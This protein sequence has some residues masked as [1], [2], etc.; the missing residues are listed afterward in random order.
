MLLKEW[1]NEILQGNLELQRKSC[2]LYIFGNASGISGGKELVVIKPNG[3]AY[4][5]L[6]AERLLVTN[7][8]GRVVEGDLRPSSHLAT[9]LVL[10][11]KFASVGGI[12]HTRSQYA[13]TGAQALQSILCFGR[14]HADYFQR[15]VVVTRSMRDNEI[16][17]A[18]Q[19]NTGD[20]IARTFDEIDYA[21]V[22]AGLVASH[23]PFTCGP[24]AMTAA[25]TAVVLEMLARTAYLTIGIDRG[26][27][28]ISQTF[29][30]KHDLRKHGTN[31]CY[32]QVRNQE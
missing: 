28:A 19:K 31:A 17:S 24:D 1:R 2:R 29:Q 30:D 22:P 11:K 8:Q 27:G 3:V 21:A 20:V 15:P 16:A 32:G 14:T 18:Y 7:L 12:A 9:H 23:G 10:Y 6:T 4:E 5:D 25:Q 26:P 13:T